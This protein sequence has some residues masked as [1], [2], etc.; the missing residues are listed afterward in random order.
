MEEF[1]LDLA[2]VGTTTV[3]DGE[4]K[5]F[6]H[7]GVQYSSIYTPEVDLSATIPLNNFDN[8]K[9]QNFEYASIEHQK[10]SVSWRN[11]LIF[12]RNPPPI[13]PTDHV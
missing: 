3:A 12:Q 13:F 8:R 2:G 7:K 10:A 5:A 1:N 6:S 11:M 9:R 4:Q